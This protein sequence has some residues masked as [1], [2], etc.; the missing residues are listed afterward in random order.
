MVSITASIFELEELARRC[1]IEIV[2]M[3]HRAQAGHPGGSLS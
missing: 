1:R 2:K 3:V